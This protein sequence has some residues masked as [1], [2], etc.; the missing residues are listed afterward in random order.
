[1]NETDHK[2]QPP[3]GAAIDQRTAAAIDQGLRNFMLRVYNYMAM[4]VAV[5]ACLV[6]AAMSVPEIAQFA[7]TARWPVFGGILVMSFFSSNLV[8]MRS[9]LMAHACY[10]LYCALWGLAAIPLV[11]LV[12]G[13]GHQQ[14][15]LQAF[16]IAV[17]TF[18]TASLFGYVTR[19]N[20][21]SFV[22]IAAMAIIGL[23]IAFLLNQFVFQSN[24]LSL[25]VSIAAVLLFTFVTAWETQELKDLY[26]EDR[27]NGEREAFAIYGAFLIYGSFMMLFLN[28]LRILW[29]F[30]GEE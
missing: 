26:L 28:I 15:V 21:G 27:Q 20:L 11:Y 5:T 8:A 9:P 14:L 22:G 29:Y 18:V 25:Y 23:L 4:G 6:L 16:V 1:M 10:W 30:V 12:V 24:E 3:A 13:A 19:I 7:Q 2:M 17:A